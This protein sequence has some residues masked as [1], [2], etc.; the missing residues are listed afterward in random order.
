MR[1][2]YYAAL[3]KAK[4]TC[5]KCG[6]IDSIN[7]AREMGKIKTVFRA[8]ASRQN[9]KLGGRPKRKVKK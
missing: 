1:R 4:H 2:E 9:G 7:P 3:M 8:E 6:H 5:T